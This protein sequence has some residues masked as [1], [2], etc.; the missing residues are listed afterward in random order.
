MKKI[1][2]TLFITS[3]I[4]ACK[5]DDTNTANP[6]IVGK[7]NLDKVIEWNSPVGGSTKKDTVTYT[8]SGSYIDIRAN[9]KSYDKN[10]KASSTSILYD[11]ANYFLRAD[12]LISYH[13]TDTSRNK[14][15]TLTNNTL[16]LNGK[17]TIGTSPITNRE[18][19]LY[20]SK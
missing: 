9:G 7:W 5:K 11:T 8:G 15:L 10:T 12:T 17:F 14:I 2:L 13:T 3:T 20:L 18:R 19:W 1:L 16:I 4:Y 6:S